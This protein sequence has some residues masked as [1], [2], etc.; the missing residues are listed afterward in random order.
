MPPDAEASAQQARLFLALVPG[1]EVQAALDA[2]ARAWRWSAEA[3]RYAPADWHLTLHFIGAVP[4][5]RLGELPAALAL[6]FTPFELRFGQPALWPHGLAVLLPIATPPALQSLHERLGVLLRQLGL[7]TDARPFR[8]HLTLARHAGQ[9]VPPA[10]PAWGWPVR[11][12]ALMAST[13]RPGA[14]YRRLQSY[15]DSGG[16]GLPPV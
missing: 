14:R 2:H 12:Y 1:A 11:A 3:L 13:G 4:Q 10:P 8:P 5:A 9:A 15:G 6:P 16:A 7:R